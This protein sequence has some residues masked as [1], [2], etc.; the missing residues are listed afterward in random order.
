MSGFDDSVGQNLWANSVFL[1]H[2]LYSAPV[3][4]PRTLVD[5]N[6]AVAVMCSRIEDK[7]RSGIDYNTRFS[8]WWR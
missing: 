4:T 2:A 6:G 7:G 1:F 8:A 3:S 5:L